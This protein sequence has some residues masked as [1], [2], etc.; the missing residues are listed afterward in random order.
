M[1]QLGI[2][3]HQK[4][5]VFN[6]FAPGPDGGSLSLGEGSP[7]AHTNC[8]GSSQGCEYEWKHGR[9]ASLDIQSLME[10]ATVRERFSVG[11]GQEDLR[12]GRPGADGPGADA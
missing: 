3:V 7:A 4:S 11:F 9:P 6:V 1:L 10:A 2:D 12:P 8:S 5:S